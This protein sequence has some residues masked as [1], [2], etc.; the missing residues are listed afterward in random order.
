MKKWFKI[1]VEVRE[2][3]KEA[4][5]FWVQEQNIRGVWEKGA[6]EM[7][8]YSENP[9]V[10]PPGVKGREE[11]E[12]E[13]EW[14]YKW[15]ESFKPV[16]VGERIVVRPPWEDPRD[17]AVEL[18]VYPAYAFGT[19]QHPTTYW[20]LYLV[21]KYFKQGQSFLDI[22]SGSG[23][24]SLLAVKLEGGKIVAVDIDPQAREELRR[25]LSLNG[26]E[27]SRVDFREGEIAQ[28]E[29]QF[30]F[31]VCNIGTTFHLLH[32][33]TMN[34]LLNEEGILVLSGIEEKDFFLLQEKAATLGLEEKEV[35]VDSFWVSVAYKKEKNVL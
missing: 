29:E 24:L 19:G 9:I 34:N 21:D 14:A 23:I 22:G 20:C 16:R 1:T 4:L 27:L 18:V 10:L 3:E 12:E 7:I 30:D 33:E 32:L 2:E 26:I 17:A 6:D 31:I 13:G 11:E 25:N 28:I 5:L 35:R 15:R 8:I